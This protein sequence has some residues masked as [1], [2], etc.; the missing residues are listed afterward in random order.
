MIVNDR[1]FVL[2]LLRV[3]STRLI[4]IEDVCPVGRG[5]LLADRGLLGRY[6]LFLF[7]RLLRRW[8]LFL[9]GARSLLFLSP[10][11][12]IKFLSRG[13]LCWLLSPT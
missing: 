5:S 9:L 10:H 11:W 13:N 6:W 7:L 12:L 8:L 2:R 4:F 1:D 3:I